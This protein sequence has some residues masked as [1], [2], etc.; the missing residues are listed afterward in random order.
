MFDLISNIVESIVRLFDGSKTSRLSQSA[1]DSDKA[2]KRLA[3]LARWLGVF[4]ILMLAFAFLLI[5]G[6]N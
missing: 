4:L 3:V 2:H 5:L 6:E 1:S